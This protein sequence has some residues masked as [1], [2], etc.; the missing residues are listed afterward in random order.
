[1]SEQNRFRQSINYKRRETEE[2]S[3][4]RDSYYGAEYYGAE[5]ADTWQDAIQTWLDRWHPYKVVAETPSEDGKS[6]ILEIQFDPLESFTLL[7]LKIKATFI[8]D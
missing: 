2:W 1:M 7:G 5:T 6:G 3:G 8:D 4:W